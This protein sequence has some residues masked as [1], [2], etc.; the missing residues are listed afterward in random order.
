[1]IQEC[2]T[3]TGVPSKVIKIEDCGKIKTDNLKS[4]DIH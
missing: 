1:M 4:K 2:V 3:S